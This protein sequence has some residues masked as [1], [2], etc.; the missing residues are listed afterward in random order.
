MFPRP[1]SMSPT[2]LPA[3][4]HLN[5]TFIQFEF[6]LA[7]S[8]FGRTEA[9]PACAWMQTMHSKYDTLSDADD[10]PAAQ[11]SLSM[12]E[13]ACANSRIYAQCL[14]GAP[15]CPPSKVGDDGE[16]GEAR[17]RDPDRADPTAAACLRYHCGSQEVSGRLGVLAARRSTDVAWPLALRLRLGER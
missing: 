13:R 17:T 1:S 16:A 7:D 12:I 3:S 6:L 14:P 5:E 10:E 8:F 9:I 15:D 2:R 4:W 11:R